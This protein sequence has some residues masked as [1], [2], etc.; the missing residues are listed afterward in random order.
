MTASSTRC[1]RRLELLSALLAL[2]FLVFAAVGAHAQGIE[3]RRASLQN[4]DDGYVLEADF[5]VVLTHTLEEALNKGVPLYFQLEFELIR[6][7]WYWFNEK[8]AGSVQDYRL[9]FNPLT[10]QYRLG[11]GRL[12]QNFATL[13]EAINV[14]SHIRRREDIPPGAL[15]K[16][17]TYVGAVRLR[18][19]TS[20]LP[21]P[22]QV[23]AL[24]SR[25]W[26]LSSDWYRW[27]ISP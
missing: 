17:N 22:F 20:Q 15:H 19:D 13:A 21:K 16:D 1:C 10:R 12:H 25:E 26:Q 7:R 5:D 27:T 23:N 6:P 14:M 3:V 24:G 2:W 11:V 18:L 8:I 9:A 4:A